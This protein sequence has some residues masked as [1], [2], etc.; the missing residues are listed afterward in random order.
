M[1]GGRTH[2]AVT[3]VLGAGFA[4]ATYVPLLASH[5]PARLAALLERAELDALVVDA[6]G[7]AVLDAEAI[8]GVPD[9]VLDLSQPDALAAVAPSEGPPP[10]YEPDDLAYIMFTSGTTGTPKGVMVMASNVDRFLAAMR[11]RFEIRPGDRCSQFF[12]LTFDLSVFDLFVGLGA[13]AT[14]YMVDDKDRLAPCKFIQKHELE[15]WFSVPSSA[16]LARR[17]RQLR[18]GSLPGVRLSLFCG[19]PLPAPLAEAWREAAPDS[20]LEN[21]YGPTEATVA[22]LG[23]PCNE[24]VLETPERGSVAIGTPFADMEVAVI[25]TERNF[26]KD[27]EDR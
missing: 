5:P 15:V 26:L 21:L 14:L 2:E 18:P 20:E 9:A 12:E 3:G 23:M 1:L 16:A 6:H 11:E 17:T 7:R 10:C 24:S 8:A 25:D 4:G 22:C 19:E 27:G 13:G